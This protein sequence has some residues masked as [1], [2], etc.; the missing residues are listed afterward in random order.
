MPLFSS[1][2]LNCSFWQGQPKQG[3]SLRVSQLF[4]FGRMRAAARS[5]LKHHK[6]VLLP[7]EGLGVKKGVGFIGEQWGYVGAMFNSRCLLNLCGHGSAQLWSSAATTEPRCPACW[8]VTSL[9]CDSRV[10]W[11]E[12]WAWNPKILVWVSAPGQGASFL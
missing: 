5:L 7:G 2:F 6:T 4:Y 12:A 11:K 3:D 1:P 9:C 10:Q 8:A